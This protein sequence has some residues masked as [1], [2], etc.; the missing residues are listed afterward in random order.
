MSPISILSIVAILSCTF[1]PIVARAQDGDAKNRNVVLTQDQRDRTILP[2]P[3]SP[4]KGKIETVMKNSTQD[5]PQPVKAPK[6]APNVLIILG[7]DIGFGTPSAFGGPVNTPVFDRI[8]KQGLR[9]TDFHTTPVCAPSRA[10]LLTG[11]NSHSVGFGTIP[12]N[13]AGFPGY[14]AI[15]PP[16]AANVL[17]ILRMNG[18]GTAWIGKADNTLRVGSHPRWTVRPMADQGCRVFLWLLWRGSE[19][20]LYTDLAEPDASKAAQNAGRGLYLR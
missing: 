17:E 11:R 10:A 15:M 18:Y 9:Y 14:D 16:S 3:E 13:A 19:P 4:F 20:I 5:W 7:D 6:G 12:D 2:P 1:C 8:A